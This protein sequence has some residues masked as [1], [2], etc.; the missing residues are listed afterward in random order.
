MKKEINIFEI[1]G[2][3]YWEYKAKITKEFIL[4]ELDFFRKTN[5]PSYMFINA[6]LEVKDLQQKIEELRRRIDAKNK[7]IYDD[8]KYHVLY[9]F[10]FI[11]WL[12]VFSVWFRTIVCFFI[13]LFS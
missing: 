9:W 8:K 3:S 7:I 2:V 10:M 5:R 4:D 12:I 1:D 11:I 6:L 13:K